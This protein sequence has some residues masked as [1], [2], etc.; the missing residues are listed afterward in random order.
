[1]S[2]L[3]NCMI[4]NLVEEFWGYS[5]FGNTLSDQEVENGQTCGICNSNF[6]EKE[7]SSSTIAAH[8]D[9]TP[10]AISQHIKVLF[11]SGLVVVRREGTKKY[12]SLTNSVTMLCCG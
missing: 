10:S 12:R 5:G 4:K 3:Q 1:M 7:L 6:N 9:I 11:E 8:F 2:I